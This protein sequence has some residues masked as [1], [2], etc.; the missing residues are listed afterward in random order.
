M[1]AASRQSARALTPIE[2]A[3]AR[4]ARAAL[5]PLV[6]QLPPGALR[7]SLHGALCAAE[8]ALGERRTLPARA[9]R[10]GER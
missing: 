1:S 6:A 9:E 3:A 10:H 5:A 8:T 4:E 7:N 2:Q